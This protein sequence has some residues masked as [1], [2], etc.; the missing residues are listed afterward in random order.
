MCDEGCSSREK[1]EREKSVVDLESSEKAAQRGTGTIVWEAE[2]KEMKEG[3]SE[4]GEVVDEGEEVNSSN[5]SS[6]SVSSQS[7]IV[8]WLCRRLYA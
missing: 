4:L 1:D 3:W 2:E 6:D 7:V 5:I 8:S